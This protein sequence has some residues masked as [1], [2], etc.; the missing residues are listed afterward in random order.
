MYDPSMYATQPKLTTSIIFHS[1]GG[2]G[3]LS[4][5]AA[6]RHLGGKDKFDVDIYEASPVLTEIG[7]G[8]N[9]WPRSWRIMEEIGVQS[10]LAELLFTLPKEEMRKF[11]GTPKD[12]N[13][14]IHFSQKRSST[15]ERP[16][17][18][19]ACLLTTSR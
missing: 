17:N 13:S 3:G 12:R 11:Y 7:A 19:K 8:I 4:L 15:P 1:G 6:L 5:A 18:Q 2:I 16:T 9:F 10:G 14:L